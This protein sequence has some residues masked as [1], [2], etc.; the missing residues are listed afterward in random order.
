VDPTISYALI[1][2]A[3]MAV[4]FSLVIIFVYIAIRFRNWQYGMGGVVALAHDSLIII[5]MFTLFHGILP[6]SMEIDQHFI[7]AL[8]TVIGYSIMDTVIIFDRIREYN[9]LYPKRD[10]SVNINGAI[11]STLGR[12][13]NTSG[14]TFVTL[15]VIFIFGGEVLR[16]FMFALLVGVISGTYSSVFNATP[17]AY[18][19]IMWGKRR[20]EKKELASKGK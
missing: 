19:L 13:I 10:L 20:K 18:D 2:Q 1:W 7:A 3:F 6:F 12:T 4:I 15:I 9:K 8:L 14:I 17:I 11:N 16:G 5:T